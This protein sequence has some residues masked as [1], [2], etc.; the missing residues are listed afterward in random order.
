MEQATRSLFGLRQER[1]A[2]QAS[3]GG[4][5]M[6]HQVYKKCPCRVCRKWYR[7][8]PRLGERQRTCGEEACK[9]EWNLRL[10]ANRRSRERMN[11]RG[12][13]LR[14][15]LQDVGIENL[16]K[17]PDRA[18]NMKAV[19]HSIDPEVLVLVEEVA[20]VTREW[21]RH[22]IPVQLGL[23]QGK[24]HRH[25]RFNQRHPIAGIGPPA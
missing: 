20:R 17:E 22:S 11:D 7:P 24:S 14:D 1:N 23:E 25:I 4:G 3:I 15:R 13:R 18:L 6:Q 10:C 8:D 5:E 12:N 9:R 2:A 19:R 16:G 21:V